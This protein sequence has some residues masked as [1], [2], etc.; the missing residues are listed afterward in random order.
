MR[1]AL[2]MRL[3]SSYGSWELSP[4]ASAPRKRTISS[5]VIRGTEA[6]KEKTPGNGIVG[7]VRICDTLRGRGNMVAFLGSAT[8]GYKL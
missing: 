4:V 7:L 6:K 1:L 3:S 2:I 8:Q 5:T